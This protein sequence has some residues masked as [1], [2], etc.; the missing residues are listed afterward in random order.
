[1]TPALRLLL[2]ALLFWADVAVADGYDGP[3]LPWWTNS[4][5]PKT[6]AYFSCC[7]LR[8]SPASAGAP[9]FLSFLPVRKHTTD[10]L[11]ANVEAA[12]LPPPPTRRPFLLPPSASLI[13]IS[14]LL[15]F[16]FPEGPYVDFPSPA[17]LGATARSRSCPS[18]L[19]FP[20]PR[21]YS[22]PAAFS[23]LLPSVC[24]GRQNACPIGRRQNLR[25]QISLQLLLSD[26]P[27]RKRPTPT[28]LSA[29][30]APTALVSTSCGAP[31]R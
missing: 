23:P 28:T 13:L 2:M 25:H 4:T 12:Y 11:P 27:P 21:K 7:S 10:I 18:R 26:S 8:A 6:S 1:M 30:L 17:I 31:Y 19:Q 29:S 24:S 16:F 5:L 20:P 3:I 15:P 9:N 22:P 14:G